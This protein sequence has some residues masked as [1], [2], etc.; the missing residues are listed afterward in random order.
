MN[1]VRRRHA[2]LVATLII[3]AVAVIAAGQLATAGAAP[4]ADVV[5]QAMNGLTQRGIPVDAWQL[6]DTTL[7]VRLSSKSTTDVGTPDDPINLSL[8]EREAFLAKSRGVDLAQ[9]QID[10]IN[11]AGKS[12]FAGTLNL[13][14]T[15]GSDWTAAGEAMSESETM[16]A[17]DAGLAGKSDLAGLTVKTFALKDSSGVRMLSLM[18]TTPDI[19]TANRST[20]ELMTGLH[21]L[22]DNLN[23]GERAQIALALVEIA[24]E[25]GRPL[26]KWIYDAQRGAQ[27]WWQAPGMTTDWFESPGPQTAETAVK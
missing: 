12:L 11:A 3:M 9:L 19:E 23:A 20:A 27:N 6:D 5:G 14:Q 24:D 25:S 22:I 8:V 13:S 10:V 21:V 15:L 16:A 1:R 17:L 2:V 26:L 7:S 4:N 18:A